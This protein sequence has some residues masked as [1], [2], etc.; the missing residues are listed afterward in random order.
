MIKTQSTRFAC[1]LLLTACPGEQVVV[2]DIPSE[3]GNGEIEADE[4]CDDGNKEP[5]DGCTDGCVLARCGPAGRSSGAGEGWRSA[6]ESGALFGTVS[7]Y[8]QTV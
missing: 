5:G 4:T 2:R 7:W 6:W 3:C 1:L 8:H